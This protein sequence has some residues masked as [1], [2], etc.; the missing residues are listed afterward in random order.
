ME[1][2]TSKQEETDQEG[3]QPLV[4][5]GSKGQ[6]GEA[7]SAGYANGGCENGDTLTASGKTLH[8]QQQQQQF[9]VS[10]GQ[11][12]FPQ[13]SSSS[14]K[15]KV[16]S[17]RGVDPHTG[18]SDPAMPPAILTGILPPLNVRS[19][20][21]Q[22]WD[23][24]GE[25]SK[26]GQGIR[27][28]RSAALTVISAGTLKEYRRSSDA[29]HIDLL[30][31]FVPDMLINVSAIRMLHTSRRTNSKSWDRGSRFTL[32][33]ACLQMARQGARKVCRK[34][35]IYSIRSSL[36]R[37]RQTTSVFLLSADPN[38][39][40][41]S[42]CGQCLNRAHHWSSATCTVLLDHLRPWRNQK[43]FV[44]S[45]LVRIDPFPQ[46]NC[47]W[48]NTSCG[49][50]FYAVGRCALA[51]FMKVFVSSP[52]ANTE[53]MSLPFLYLNRQPYFVQ[54][55]ANMQVCGTLPRPSQ[56]SHVV[57]SCLLTTDLPTGSRSAPHARLTF[58]LTPH[59]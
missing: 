22:T 6:G 48:C 55:T 5:S 21:S 40:R 33:F 12:P 18:Q 24:N 27:S 32:R 42:H 47:S 52:S 51:Y 44:L 37:T 20:D 15:M 16:P 38:F 45:C 1:G 59:V 26:S 11:P 39:L 23:S 3:G 34:C 31:V 36:S 46:K 17:L 50:P 14:P 8:G 30:R 54:Q 7:G 9:T 35:N 10:A 41:S 58:P 13:M 43:R 53:A 25:Y 56:R 29:M 2:D 4:E 49:R 28:L 19:R 57:S